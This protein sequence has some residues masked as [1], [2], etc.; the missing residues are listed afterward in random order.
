MMAIVGPVDVDQLAAAFKAFE[1]FKNRLLTADDI[2]TIQNRRVVKRS[3]W[4]KWRLACNVSDRVLEQKRTPETGVDQDGQFSWRVVTE[5]YH[6][7]T[8]RARRLHPGSDQVEE[9]RHERSDWRRRGLGRGTRHDRPGAGQERHDDREAETVT[10]RI[11]QEE[12]EA[13]DRA[14]LQEEAGQLFGLV[15][16]KQ[17]ESDLWLYSRLVE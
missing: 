15:I 7:P 16:P 5:V 14:R 2:V 17:P 1:D 3:G 9:P 8:G 10:D 12:R 4:A 6:I 13:R 11:S